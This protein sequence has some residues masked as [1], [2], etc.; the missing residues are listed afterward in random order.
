[1]RDLQAP[2]R[3]RLRC[4]LVTGPLLLASCTDSDAATGS[5]PVPLS[6]KEVRRR[7]NEAL[8]E[9]LSSKIQGMRS[10]TMKHSLCLICQDACVQNQGVW[11]NR[12]WDERPCK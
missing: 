11:P 12:L 8:H 10:E 9:C 7:C 4:L 1:M 2:W 3:R 6:P 5:C